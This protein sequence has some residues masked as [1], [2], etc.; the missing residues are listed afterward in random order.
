MNF[1]NKLD[2]RRLERLRYE[3]TS[4]KQSNLKKPETGNKLET[5]TQ[6]TREN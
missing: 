1:H 4:Q 3:N 6:E 5:V 2:L